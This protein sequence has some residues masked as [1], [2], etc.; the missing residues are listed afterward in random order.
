M[1][2]IP[3]LTA[4]G[5]SLAEAWEESLL[6]LATL[7]T[8]VATQYDAPNDPPSK[9]CSMM[10]VV[11]EPLTEPMIHVDMPGGLADLQEYVMEVCEGIKDHWIRDPDDPDD[12]RWEYTYSGRLF[13][14]PLG[15]QAFDQIEDVCQQ[16]SKCLYTRRA[17]AVVW[18]V[19]T[20][21]TCYDPPCLQSIWCRILPG[22]ELFLNMNVR[23]RSRDAYKA[24][25]MNMFALVQ[26][27]KRMAGRIGELIGQEVKL[28]RYVDFSDSYHI[29]GKNLAE[30]N[31]RFMKA[32]QERTFQQR[33]MRYC[34]I[35]DMMEEAI[36]DIL[37][38][39][40][41]EEN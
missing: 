27:Q 13:K 30:F 7:G 2:D 29:Y 36:P 16:L 4:Y 35:H 19:G 34:D 6:N 15:N 8:E 21:N 38:K 23:F 18:Q 11:K 39:V 1:N 31:G 25:F 37:K 41:D 5:T 12:K 9:D 40:A 22:D 17:Q 14:Y 28:G 26:L 3:V 33:T 32:I 10:I 20:D 24:A